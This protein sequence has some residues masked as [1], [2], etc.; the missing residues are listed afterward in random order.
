MSENSSPYIHAGEPHWVVIAREVDGE[1]VIFSEND[2]YLAFPSIASAEQYMHA[3]QWGKTLI[4]Q[5]HFLP[6]ETTDEPEAI[7]PTCPCGHP[8]G[9]HTAL[10]CQYMGCKCVTP[11][12]WLEH[13]AK[14]VTERGLLKAE[15]KLLKSKLSEYVVRYN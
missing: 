13:V 3:E 4:D 1:R 10:G 7:D 15:V 14:L 5:C 6:V 12:I 9:A 8:I 11:S 2:Q